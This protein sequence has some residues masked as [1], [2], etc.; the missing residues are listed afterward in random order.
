MA[1]EGCGGGGSTGSLTFLRPSHNP[2]S[3]PYFK[4]RRDN[5]K[6]VKGEGKKP[7]ENLRDFFSPWRPLEPRFPAYLPGHM[8]TAVGSDSWPQR[9]P[10]LSPNSALSYYDEKIDIHARLGSYTPFLCR[11]VIKSHGKCQKVFPKLLSC[12]LM[13]I[14]SNLGN[15]VCFFSPAA[16]AASL[17]SFNKYL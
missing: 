6:K 1:R 16:I 17:H 8:S 4:K 13:I 5:K 15:K 10:V 2:L 11:G 7:G 14:W 3:F 9:K 12:S